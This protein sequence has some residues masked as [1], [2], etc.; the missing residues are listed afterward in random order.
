V[1]FSAFFLAGMIQSE[2]KSPL[3]MKLKC[4]L[5][6][7]MLVSVAPLPSQAFQRLRNPLVMASG[8]L[9]KVPNAAEKKRI[10]QELDEYRKLNNVISSKLYDITNN[11]STTTGQ[12]RQQLESLKSEKRELNKQFFTTIKPY[13]DP[14]KFEKLVRFFDS[15]LEVQYV[16]RDSGSNACAK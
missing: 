10:T 4:F 5:L 2:N 13:T 7:S 6:A 9:S 8:Q 3:I 16:C 11:L 15:V 12:K 14:A 1:I